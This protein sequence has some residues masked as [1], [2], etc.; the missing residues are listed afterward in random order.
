VIFRD[1]AY[2]LVRR[3]KAEEGIR[4]IRESYRACLET[5]G[6]S[7][8]WTSGAEGN[9]LR[10]LRA[11][12]RHE[13][14]RAHVKS[15]LEE[16]RRRAEREDASAEEINDYAWELLTCWPPELRRPKAALRLAEKALEKTAPED[17]SGI[18]DTA[19]KADQMLGDL[20]A[21]I[22]TQRKAVALLESRTAPDAGDLVLELVRYLTLAGDV[23]AA[24]EET[25]RQVRL[26]REDAE[27]EPADLAKDLRGFGRDLIREGLWPAGEIALLEAVA[28]YEEIPA[29][30]PAGTSW[31]APIGGRRQSSITERRSRYAAPCATTGSRHV[32]TL[33]RSSHIN[34]S[35]WRRQRRQ[36]GSPAN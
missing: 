12:D 5:Y 29:P 8:T 30:D 35:S 36:V 16:L 2:F 13:E 18:L 20:P 23:D 1:L 28:A 3:G 25:H 26:M 11:D 21:A 33:S 14:A 15:G 22:G 9:L 32:D 31:G 17:S 10:I 24:I 19:A 4:L 7:N 34:W 6:E 27:G